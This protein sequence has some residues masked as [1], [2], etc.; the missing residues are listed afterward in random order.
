MMPFDLLK[1]S[2]LD[3][4][5]ELRETELRL[6]LGGGYGLYLKRQ[7]IRESGAKTLLPVF[8]EARSTNDLD[9]FL[10]T[11]ILADPNSARLLE[12]TL[13]HLGYSAIESA[14]Y[15]Q[16]SREITIQGDTRR[17]KIDLLTGP[18]SHDVDPA[19][20]RLEDNRRIK[21]RDK[22][23]RL[24][25]RLTPEAVAIDYAPV[26][27]KVH[28][29]RSTG[30]EYAGIVFLPHAFAYALMKLVASHDKEQRNDLD[31]ARKH[32][33]DLYLILAMT[34]SEEWDTAQRFRSEYSAE[35]ILREAA[36]II[37]DYFGHSEAR[38]VLRLREHPQFTHDMDI[39]EFLSILA[40][41]FPDER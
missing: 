11:E 12:E 30:E 28:G 41:L 4:L 25:A 23:I 29:Q 22:T 15:Y 17:V 40:E 2:L 9:V 18:V 8:P 7:F 1:A 39:R 38:G 31:G 37:L 16:F 5:Y 34:T 33:L 10:R 35:P 13:Y 27:I 26:E 24:H 6:I 32:A 14:K 20:L 19:R 3:L 21:P 36:A